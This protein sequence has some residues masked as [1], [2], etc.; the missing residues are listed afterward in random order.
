MIDDQDPVFEEPAD[1]DRRSEPTEVSFKIQNFDD[2]SQGFGPHYVYDE[3][4]KLMEPNFVREPSF[5]DTNEARYLLASP[6]NFN[7]H[8]FSRGMSLEPFSDGIDYS[9]N[10]RGSLGFRESRS[11]T[12]SPFSISS[13]SYRPFST[14]PLKEIPPVEDPIIL[15]P[16]YKDEFGY[17]FD[18]GGVE[19]VLNL[20]KVEH[21]FKLPKSEKYD[22][23]WE[24]NNK[25]LE[26]KLAQSIKINKIMNERLRKSAERV[27]NEINNYSMSEVISEEKK[28]IFEE[29]T[30][31]ES[32]KINI[33][34]WELSEQFKR[35]VLEV[36]KKLKEEE[37]LRK[38][39]EGEEKINQNEYTRTVE[40]KQFTEQNEYAVTM[41]Q[42]IDIN[43]VEKTAFNIIDENINNVKYAEKE[44][45][46][47]NVQYEKLIKTETQTRNE[48]EQITNENRSFLEEVSET[49]QLVSEKKENENLQ[50]N[51]K[52]DENFRTDNITISSEQ[53]V[54][55]INKRSKNTAEKFE[56][57]AETNTEIH[58]KEYEQIEEIKHK[59]FA[60]NGTPK[61]NYKEETTIREEKTTS[62]IEDFEII[63]DEKIKRRSI[64]DNVSDQ[65]H[66]QARA[67]VD[68]K[69]SVQQRTFTEDVLTKTQNNDDNRTDSEQRVYT[70]GLQTIPNIR[71]VV[72]SQHYDLLLKTFFIHLTDVM[73]ALSRFMLTQPVLADKLGNGRQQER[74]RKYESAKE[75]KVEQKSEQRKGSYVDNKLHRE[76]FSYTKMNKEMSKDSRERKEQ[77]NY[78]EN[79]LLDIEKQEKK[80]I[81][82]K[83]KTI[84]KMSQKS[85]EVTQ[86]MDKVITEFQNKTEEVRRIRRSSSRSSI[87]EEVAQ[88]SDPLEWLD[89]VNSRRS[90]QEFSEISK[91]QFSQSKYDSKRETKQESKHITTCKSKPGRQIY[92]AIVE[93]HVYTNPDVIFEDHT[94]EMLESTTYETAKSTNL[95]IESNQAIMMENIA[96]QN[97]VSQDTGI[98]KVQ[99]GHT[100][101]RVQMQNQATVESYEEN[102]HNVTRMKEIN[103]KQHAFER[104]TE[105]IKDILIQETREVIE[106]VVDIKTETKLVKQATATKQ[107]MLL[108][109]AAESTELNEISKHEFLD[110]KKYETQKAGVKTDN[111]R[112]IEISEIEAIKDEVTELKLIKNKTAEAKKSLEVVDNRALE[113]NEIS[114]ERDSIEDL[115]I[116]KTQEATAE[117]SVD[118]ISAVQV[119]EIVTDKDEF[120]VLKLESSKDAKANQ[121]IEEATAME[122]S[123]VHTITDE[124]T[125]LKIENEKETTAKQ[126]FEEAKSIIISETIPDKIEISDFNIQQVKQASAITS[127]QEGNAAVQVSEVITEKD[128][129]KEIKVHQKNSEVAQRSYEVTSALEVSEINTELT[130]LN[131][132]ELEVIKSKEF[133]AQKSIQ[134]ATAIEVAEYKSEKNEIVEFE[135]TKEQEVIASEL[136]EETRAKVEINEVI[137]KKDLELEKAAFETA[138]MKT[139][140]IQDE[141]AEL[142]IIKHQEIDAEYTDELDSAVEITEIADIAIKNEFEERRKVEKSLYEVSETD[143]EIQSEYV[144]LN[145]AKQ[146]ILGIS[147]FTYDSSLEISETHHSHSMNQTIINVNSQENNE[148]LQQTAVI[149]EIESPER[150]PSPDLPTPLVDEYVF[151]L[152]IPLPKGIT[153]VPPDPSPIEEKIV[154]VDEDPH[155]VKKKLVPHIDLSIEA[156]VFDPPLPSPEVKVCSPIYRKPGLRG[157]ADRPEYRKASKITSGNLKDFIESFRNFI[158][159]FCMKRYK[160]FL[161]R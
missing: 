22:P 98:A 58:N 104:Q 12:A 161:K 101:S 28:E 48:S 151:K 157:G 3:D 117:K 70:L 61:P 36:K 15:N 72:H 136:T 154:K 130:Q 75:Q 23:N 76:E 146:Q 97:A 155:I 94:A 112:A 1:F 145:L 78:V 39:T 26:E 24:E 81:E 150:T 43:Q 144:A 99:D 18:E 80:V 153:P 114:I 109:T 92:R 96:V 121:V 113:I 77:E 45:T 63:C 100:F 140:T 83:K 50:E 64:N 32:K 74:E 54:K 5:L 19:C 143:A 125:E 105:N 119:T 129:I 52:M 147:E 107:E 27:L 127:F 7:G 124:V 110:V 142:K 134:E 9:T 116:S 29:K 55:E 106:P 158:S 123:E 60:T 69:N 86:K 138:K 82:N 16:N 38:K 85:E 2:P 37:Q 62:K 35:E 53:Q 40:M 56:P 141:F 93:A 115:K 44:L 131:I 65:G 156:A 139:E 111:F 149:T 67:E 84:A 34:T 25:N 51:T 88:E 10:G 47:Q 120:G 30:K 20:P 11:L 159:S 133:V 148:T 103:L 6:A 8:D 71:G 79:N 89:K 126:A 49:L 41:D 91:K 137:V 135:T 108:H 13:K 118:Q 14:E 102:L 122:I 59:A 17:K 42:E 31:C 160:L 95:A 87:E 46:T 21:N 132:E 57:K 66:I 152:E 128:E 4:G 73:V 33:S 90:S 68:S